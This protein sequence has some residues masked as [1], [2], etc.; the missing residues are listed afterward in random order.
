VCLPRTQAACEPASRPVEAGAAASEAPAE[1]TAGTV[2]VVEDQAQVRR[3]VLAILRQNGYR[4]LEAADGTEALSLCERHEGALD[5]LI[6][7]V[8]MPGM[9]GV[10]LSDR[11]R[12][13]R[14]TLRTLFISGYTADV[15]GPSGALAPGMSHLAKPFSPAQL[16]RKIREVLGARITAR[17][18]VIDDDA[19]VRSLLDR[20]LTDS[21]Y[22]VRLAADGNDGLRLASEHPVDVVITDLVMPEREGLETIPALRKLHPEAWIVAISGAFGGQYL[23]AARMLGADRTLPKPVDREELLA[24]LR[25]LVAHPRVPAGPVEAER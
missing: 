18:L 5:L 12:R 17:L 21:G 15:L 6:T 4:L 14:P 7:D 20:L 10:E 2:M 13:L 19:G 24:V 3:M 1:T 11:M 23:K 8:V 16:S 9:N 22:E 25:E